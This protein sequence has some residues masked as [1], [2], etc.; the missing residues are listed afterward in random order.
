MTDFKKFAKAAGWRA[1]RTVAQTALGA[2]GAAVV[3]SDVDWIMVLSASVL[4]GLCSVLMSVATG[5]PEVPDESIIN[6]D[7]EGR[8]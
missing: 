2:I 3:V 7:G 5:L 1:L 6:T 4:A 8:G